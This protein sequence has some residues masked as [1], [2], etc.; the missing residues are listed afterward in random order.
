MS[1]NDS[2]TA[3]T[4]VELQSAQH[5]ADLASVSCCALHRSLPLLC[6]LAVLL[7]LPGPGPPGPDWDRDIKLPLPEEFDKNEK[8]ILNFKY[9]PFDSHG[10][11][12]NF[13]GLLVA[14][15]GCPS[16]LPAARAQPAARIWN[17]THLV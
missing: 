13:R 1:W 2:D 3:S 6:F 16:V 10:T 17:P 15:P 11:G 12:P 8:V 14:R 5:F 7:I 9:H 4:A